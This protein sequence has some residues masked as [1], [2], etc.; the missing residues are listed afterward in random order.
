MVLSG[1]L[2][3]LYHFPKKYCNHQVRAGTGLE[4][5][6]PMPLVLGPNTTG[7]QTMIGRGIVQ[8]WNDTPHGEYDQP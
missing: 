2:P 7:P 3:Y 4:Q 6:G 5:S 8:R 1:L